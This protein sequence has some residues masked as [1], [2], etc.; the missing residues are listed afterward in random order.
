M[1][2]VMGTDRNAGVLDEIRKLERGL[3][4]TTLPLEVLSL[5]APV[6]RYRDGIPVSV[7]SVEVQ[8]AI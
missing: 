1:V 6:P 2:R 5:V 8:L 4:N 3:F 7:G